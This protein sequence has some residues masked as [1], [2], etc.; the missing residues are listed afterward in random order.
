MI[1]TMCD[2]RGSMPAVRHAGMPGRARPGEDRAFDVAFE[3]LAAYASPHAG[4]LAFHG[5][6]LRPDSDPLLRTIPE[7][8]V[9]S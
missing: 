4:L 5:R 9:L 1:G 2:G 6:M 8:A 3:R 7:V